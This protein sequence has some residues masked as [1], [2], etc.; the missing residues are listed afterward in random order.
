MTITIDL[1]KVM[2]KVVLK[3]NMNGEVFGTASSKQENS[4]YLQLLYYTF[5]FK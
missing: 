2:E 1:K 3:Y 4:M 5:T